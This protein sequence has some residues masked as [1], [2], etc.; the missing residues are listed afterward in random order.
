M[1]FNFTDFIFSLNPQMSIPC[2]WSPKYCERTAFLPLQSCNHF[3][4]NDLEAVHRNHGKKCIQEWKFDKTETFLHWIIDLLLLLPHQ[5]VFHNSH[6]CLYL[7]LPSI[8]AKSAVALLFLKWPLTLAFWDILKLYQLIPSWVCQH[9]LKFYLQKY[10]ADWCDS[11]VRQHTVRHEECEGDGS[12]PDG[13]PWVWG[14]NARH[15][16]MLNLYNDSSDFR[17]YFF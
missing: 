8:P 2:K 1:V 13:A 7:I 10:N 14:T 5:A 16:L 12:S 3:F 17:R 9:M 6:S 4:H 15:T 11:L